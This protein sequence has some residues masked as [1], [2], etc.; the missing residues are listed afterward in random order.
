MKNEGFKPSK[1]WVI[2]PKIEGNVGS[3]GICASPMDP[4]LGKDLIDSQ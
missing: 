4:C 2:T 1:I 3:H